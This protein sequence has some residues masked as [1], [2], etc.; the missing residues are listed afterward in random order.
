M[1][2]VWTGPCFR[3]D[4][5]VC[6]VLWLLQVLHVASVASLFRAALNSASTQPVFMLRIALTHVQDLALGRQREGNKGNIHS[7][8]IRIGKCIGYSHDYLSLY[9]LSVCWYTQ[10]HWHRSCPL[11]SYIKQT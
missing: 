8:T 2:A 5:G 11:G 1:E 10:P 3:K 7:I 4:F 9:C 6:L